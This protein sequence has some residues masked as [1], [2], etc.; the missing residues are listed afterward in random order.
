MTVREV[1]RRRIVTVFGA[2]ALAAVAGGAAVCALGG[3]PAAQWARNPA[4]WVIGAVLAAALA[5]FQRPAFGAV[6]LWAAPAGLFAAL[7]NPGQQG[8]HRWIDPGPLHINDAMLLLPPAIVAFAGAARDGAGPWIAAFIG[9]ALLTA[10]PDASQAAALAAVIALVAARTGFRP[11]IRL[12]LIAA[13]LGLAA[14]AWMRPDPL[15][16][17]PEVEGIVGLAAA[18]SPAAGVALV[19]LLA[20]TAAAPAILTARAPSRQRDAGSA[21]SLGL[22]V[23]VIAPFLGAFPMPFAGLGP[24]PILGAWLGVGLLAGQGRLSP[25]APSR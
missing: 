20:A 21:L 15:A 16:P 23:W 24:S 7:F 22:L 13:A 2:L 10:Q 4:A 9:L 25:P 17:V 6:A 11:L 1:E 14:L 18:L 12:A 5:V 19:L 3:T 8:V